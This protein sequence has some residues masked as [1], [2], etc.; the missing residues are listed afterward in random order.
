M[1]TNP[2]ERWLCYTPDED[3]DVHQL[4]ISGDDGNITD[5]KMMPMNRELPDGLQED[6]CYL[7]FDEKSDTFDWS[8]GRV[9]RCIR[10]GTK[11]ANGFRA[12]EGLAPLPVPDLAFLGD[13]KQDSPG[14]E[15]VLQPAPAEEPERVQTPG[16]TPVGFSWRAV[17]YVE[18]VCD[19]GDVLTEKVLFRSQSR[20][21]VQITNPKKDAKMQVFAVLSELDTEPFLASVNKRF[22]RTI[23]AKDKKEAEDA[24]ILPVKTSAE[25]RHRDWADGV[26]CC[27]EE[28]FADFPLKP[29]T[30]RWCLA[31]LEE[32]PWSLGPPPHVSAGVSSPAGA[33]GCGDP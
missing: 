19:F 7:F 17:E 1:F 9:R 23:E 28:E 30:T 8:A 24:R 27:E 21:I 18:G 16:M 5:I 11:I 31:F 33:M 12:D 25:G 10:E 3:H 26:S 20:G 29:R 14:L 6:D 32:A 2:Q 4:R 13:G 15:P 22:G